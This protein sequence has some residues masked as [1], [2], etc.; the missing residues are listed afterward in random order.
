MP[1][2]QKKTKFQPLKLIKVIL[3]KPN[4]SEKFTM[5]L[6]MLEKI[7]LRTIQQFPFSR[8]VAPAL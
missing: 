1:V 7:F 5:L 2:L 4:T 8:K 6:L 3:A